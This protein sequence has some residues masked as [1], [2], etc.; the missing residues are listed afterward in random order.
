MF[1]AFDEN[2]SVSN[3]RCHNFDARNSGV[4]NCDATIRTKIS[5]NVL[6]KSGPSGVAT[7]VGVV[8]SAA[9]LLQH[10]QPWE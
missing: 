2:F 10:R 8:I 9:L 5:K 6:L 4:D 7:T 3:L 1:P